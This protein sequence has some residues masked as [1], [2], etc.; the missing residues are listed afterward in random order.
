MVS[1]LAK[2]FIKDRENT[3]EP[4]VRQAYGMLCGAVGI[5]FNIFLFLL[6]LFAGLI[7][8]SIAIM[9]DAFN[10]LSDAGSSIVTL[11]GFKMAG[12][13]A[14]NDH[15]FGHGRLEYITGFIVSVVIVV[16]G[17][18]LGKS[19]IDK[20]INPS[21]ITFEPITIAILVI[22]VGVKIYMFY[23]NRGIAKKLNS[24]SIQATA[25]DSLSDSVATTFVLLGILISEYS[26]IQLDGYL[27]ILVAAF[28]FKAGIGA[29]RDTLN[30][31]LGQAPEKEFVDMVEQFV[32][33]HEYVVGVHDLV[34]HDYGPGRRM[35]SLHTEVPASGDILE[36]HDTIDNIERELRE[37]MGCEAVIHMDPVQTDDVQVMEMKQRVAQLMKKMGEEVSIHDFRM[38]TGPT[39]TNLIFDIVVPFSVKMTE[40]QVRDEIDRLIASHLGSQYFAVVDVDKAYV[41]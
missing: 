35:I 8:G 25:T 19:A 36:L 21:A 4:K 22:S 33:S 24:A 17:F 38:V 30:P 15:P 1:L 20:I 3:T 2:W 26:G 6:K 34:V 16:M 28:I 29:A 40:M 31:L 41:V 7:S 14:D 27:G 23:Y 37:K 5:A 32:M 10:N 13:E 12:Q 11:V 39:H 9:A 18:E